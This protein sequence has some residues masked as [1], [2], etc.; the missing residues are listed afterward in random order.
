MAS[1]PGEVEGAA[2]FYYGDT[3]CLAGGYDVAKKAL[4]T[5]VICYNPLSP[6]GSPSGLPTW[7]SLPNMTYPRF[8]PAAVVLDGKLFVT[9]GYDPTTHEFLDSVEVF[10]DV[11]QK[12]Y[13]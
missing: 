3:L 4:R 11:S 9:G 8:R 5:D 1:L 7:I 2:T 13:V 10:D 12:W 6:S